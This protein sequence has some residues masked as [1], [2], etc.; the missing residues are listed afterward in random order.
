MLT[1]EQIL[2][3]RGRNEY[4]GFYEKNFNNNIKIAEKKFTIRLN[5]VYVE[6]G[7]DILIQKR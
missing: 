3:G 6:N 1:K 5:L 7:G 4:E 2:N